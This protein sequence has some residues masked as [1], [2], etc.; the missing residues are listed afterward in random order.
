VITPA[1][2]QTM[3]R[4]NRW[5]NQSIYAAAD[6]LTDGQRK[7]PRGAFFGSLH[8]TLNHLLCGDM[9][10]MNRFAGTPRPRARNTQETASEHEHWA[11]LK[12]A[13]VTFDQTI[14]DWADG[15][16]SDWLA[17]DMVWYSGIKKRELT[18]PK[19]LLVAHFFN[20]QTHHRGQAHCL[21][22]QFG[23]KP[24]DTDL[25]FMPE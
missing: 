6:T 25:P 20:H 9:M 8:G 11:D 21:L 18:R 23:A 12:A 5:Q 22:T 17:G 7:E 10:W 13:R 16:T 15:L 3:A 14:I 24:D 1:Y 19:W 2:V 4:Y